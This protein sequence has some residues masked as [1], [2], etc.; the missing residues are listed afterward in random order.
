MKMQINIA[1]NYLP[2]KYMMLP[3]LE[4]AASIYLNSKI[5]LNG[6][7]NKKVWFSNAND[8]KFSSFSASE[9]VCVVR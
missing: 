5:M 4:E 6:T 3:T 8:E 9:A 7:T 2:K 1:M